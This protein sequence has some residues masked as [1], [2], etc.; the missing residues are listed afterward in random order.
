MRWPGLERSALVSTGERV[1][2]VAMRL[3][4][5]EGPSALVSTGGRKEVAMGCRKGEGGGD[6]VGEGVVMV[7]R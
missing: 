1:V 3:P 4:G 6:E 7:A 2:K 5:P